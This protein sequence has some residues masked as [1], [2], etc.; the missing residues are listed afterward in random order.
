MRWMSLDRLISKK[1]KHGYH[2]HKRIVNKYPEALYKLQDFRIF[3]P[4]NVIMHRQNYH[5]SIYSPNIDFYV[6]YLELF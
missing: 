4:I 2:E 6:K 3:G 5:I 1:I